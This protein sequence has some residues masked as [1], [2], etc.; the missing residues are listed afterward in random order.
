MELLITSITHTIRTRKW[1]L[2]DA[3]DEEF[4]AVVKR[5]ARLKQA[6]EQ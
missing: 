3:G 6:R 5:K 2:G 4:H 1:L